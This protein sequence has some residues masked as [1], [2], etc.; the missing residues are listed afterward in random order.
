MREVVAWRPESIDPAH[1]DRNANAFGGNSGIP[2]AA[3]SQSD[4]RHGVSGESWQIRKPGRLG[5]P[6]VACITPG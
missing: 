6:V 4:L 3:V 1:P 5:G 2:A